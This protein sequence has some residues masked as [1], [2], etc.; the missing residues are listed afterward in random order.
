[1]PI[2]PV[3]LALFNK[4]SKD[5]N[6]AP[7]PRS[8][9]K[10]KC[11]KQINYD[12]L[13]AL[14]H[15]KGLRAIKNVYSTKEAH[16]NFMELYPKIFYKEKVVLPKICVSEAKRPTSEDAVL[17]D[18]VT[19]LEDVH[20]I[21]VHLRK[22]HGL[23]IG[24]VALT[25]KD[26]MEKLIT[27][28]KKLPIHRSEL[29]HAIVCKMMKLIPDI[30]AQITDEELKIISRSTCVETWM[31]GT[32]VIGNQ[33]F[34][35]IL[36]GSV[37]SQLR[38]SKIVFGDWR[39]ASSSESEKS[40]DSSSEDDS[41]SDYTNVNLKSVSSVCSTLG[42]GSSFGTLEVISGRKQRAVFAIIT[43]DDCEILKICSKE[44]SSIKEEIA[45]R[46]RTSREQLIQKCPY[47][48]NWPKL[49][50]FELTSLIKWQQ[51]PPGYVLVKAGDIISFVGFIHSGYC[52]VF[53]EIV[54]L[55]KHPPRKMGKKIRRVFLGKLHEKESFGEISVLLQVPFT[56]TIITGTEVEL[57]IIDA[58]KILD[59]DW[60]TQ[61]LMLQTAKATFGQL[62]QDEINWEYITKEKQREWQSFKD[63]VIKKTLFYN[64]I[65]PGFG[66]WTHLWVCKPNREGNSSTNKPLMD[67]N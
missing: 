3:T 67:S 48:N 47:Y 57:G 29:E 51:F 15:I 24:R 7:P 20:D 16:Q 50:L 2:S 9:P 64:G 36:K 32:T 45:R 26:K 55:V 59:L 14:C 42:I 6:Q 44:Y 60:V 52:K 56:C 1:M 33:G 31:K 5:S 17:Q 54:G 4:L 37:R 35:V 63:M 58:Q 34:Y 43:E 53:R 38:S 10:L 13:D 27:I 25:F 11:S 65:V 46:E 49:S 18:E 40:L 41:L 30:A 19:P 23:K 8:I 28:L 39:P 22:I 12:Q 66:K 62:T 61:K 21:A